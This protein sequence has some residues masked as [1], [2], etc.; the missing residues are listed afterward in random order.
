MLRHAR[1]ARGQVRYG[2]R[3]REEPMSVRSLVAALAALAVIAPAALRAQ[4]G[5]IDF[6]KARKEFISGQT[7]IA[8]NTL[9]EASLGVRQQVGR[10]R[11]EVVGAELLEAESHLE[12]IAN[13]LRAGTLKDVKVLDQAMS[14]IDRALA[15]HHL[16]VIQTHL[17]HLRPDNI[18][19]VAQDLD[20]AAY[21]F[22]RSVTLNGGKLRAEQ[23]TAVADIRKLGQEI[24]TKNAIPSSASAIVTSFLK[25]VAP[26][27]TA[28]TG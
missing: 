11:D 22:E 4:E 5:D 2:I 20:R 15:H 13:D 23:A 6:G 17:V 12:K 18:P 27:V 10:C 25:M 8:A 16:L 28:T 26:E 1:G 3:H 9:L 19:S 14:K 7:R 21:H 24:E